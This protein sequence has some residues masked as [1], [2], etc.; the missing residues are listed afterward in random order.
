MAPDS[1]CAGLTSV[2]ID[3]SS[4]IELAVGDVAALPLLATYGDGT[5]RS[6]DGVTWTSD[7]A[8]VADVAAHGITTGYAVGSA[9]LQSMKCG[10]ANTVVVQVVAVQ[11]KRE[12]EVCGTA[13]AQITAQWAANSACFPTSVPPAADCSTQSDA[14]EAA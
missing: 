12:A 2:S 1:D 9:H 14:W 3:P 11:T 10:I 7:N 8:F 5:T 4:S 13:L 6:V